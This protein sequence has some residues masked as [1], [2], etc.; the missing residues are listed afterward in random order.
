MAVLVGFV[1]SQM[2]K[3]W[4]FELLHSEHAERVANFRSADLDPQID[5]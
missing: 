1:H 5:G 4:G 3:L 2:G